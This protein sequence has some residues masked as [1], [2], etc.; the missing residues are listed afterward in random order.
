MRKLALL[1]AITVTSLGLR[2]GEPEYPKQGPDIYDPE[3]NAA[4]DITAALARAKAAHKHVLLDFGANWCVWCHRLHTTF[5]TNEKVAAAL[6]RDFVVVMVDVNQRKGVKRNAAVN[7]KYGNPI[8][9]GLPVLVVLNT[10][11]Q[12]LTTRE[13]GA[14]EDGASHSPEKIVAFLAQWA[15]PR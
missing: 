7:E 6:A 2:A 15:P 3:A 14:L 8:E 12:P 9:L 13:T 1:A 5:T 11:G 4:A 10:D